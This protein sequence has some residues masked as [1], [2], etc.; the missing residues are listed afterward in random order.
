MATEK[1]IKKDRSPDER[2]TGSLSM[3]ARHWA[4]LKELADKEGLSMSAY[5]SQKLKL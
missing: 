4:K 2:V 5:V 3:L 1:K